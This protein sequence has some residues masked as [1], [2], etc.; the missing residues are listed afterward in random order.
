MAVINAPQALYIGQ[1]R[2]TAGLDRL[3]RIDAPTFDSVFGKLPRYSSAELIEM[4]EQVDLRGR[5]G[6]A[7][8]VA[9]KLAAVVRSARERGRKPVILVNATEGEPGSAKD[10]LLL[11]RTPYLVLGGALIAASALRTAEIII[12]V[13]DRNVE[14][15]VRSAVRSTPRL[16]S[17]VQIVRVPDRFIS[18]E[19]GALVNAVNG[20]PAL[21][22]GRK[23]RA[24]DSG[25][26]G[27]PTLLSN[28]ETFAQLA[29]LA[30]LG[31]EGYA[32]VG[33]S[34]EPGTILLTM[35]GAAARH[36]VVEV[37]AGL[38]L[39]YVLD[40]CSA[41]PGDGVLVGGYHGMWLPTA[42]AYDVP[43]SRAG[44]E[45]A[46][47]ALGAGIVLP[48]S[49]GTCPIGEVARIATYLAGESSGQC[50]PCKLGLPGIARSLTAVADGSGGVEAL[51]AARRT[52]A[53][54][55]GRGACAHP[56][57]VYRF[58]QSA[59][60]VFTDDIAAHVF[61]GG[62]N[63]P[64]RGELPVPPANGELQLS[65]DWTRC[66]GHG[67][68]G[69]IVPELMQL[70]Q[71]GYPVMLDMPVPPW[72]EREARQAVQM[73]PELALRLV[74]VRAADEARPAAPAAAR[75]P[76]ERRA[77]ASVSRKQLVAGK[78]GKSGDLIVSEEWIADL[79]DASGR[80][81]PIR[82]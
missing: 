46:G 56:D 13:T 19:G 35:G 73:C 78:S 59:L 3:T 60:N 6:A 53:A 15:S 7:F 58:V 28:A 49:Y 75:R 10:R 2:L 41:N 8:P 23:V 31:P 44:L 21:P 64:V 18:G 20:K 24:S 67:L 17:F 26:R 27:L 25:A 32:S 76:A 66:R 61:Q 82:D 38:P 30:M 50:G 70:D 77:L 36:A 22:P 74:P 72:L 14:L 40:L 12:A 37:P 11:L 16:Q 34:D 9:R 71:Q 39:G 69:R 65:L 29:V 4:A 48:L 79:S 43:V 62:C 47:G 54:V 68:C 33:T 5:G 63:R 45:A 51:D 57:G 81:P 1:P 55:R 42:T 80:I 52:A